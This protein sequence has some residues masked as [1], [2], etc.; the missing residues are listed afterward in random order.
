MG[1]VTEQTLAEAKV[2]VLA[3][4]HFGAQLGLLEVLLDRRFR[5]R[6]SPR[7]D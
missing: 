6:R 4:K 7:F 3:V 2:P 1:S 5:G